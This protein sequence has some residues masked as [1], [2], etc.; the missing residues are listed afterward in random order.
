MHISRD[1]WCSISPPLGLDGL[2]VRVKLTDTGRFKI[3]DLYMHGAE[4]S[5]EALRAVSVS[6]LEAAINAP[7]SQEKG[8]LDA[9]AQGGKGHQAD[10]DLTLPALRERAV[11]VAERQQRRAR[12]LGRPTG[13][14][15][16]QFYREV[17]F[18]Y[19]ELARTTRA[20]AKT[21]A[22]ESEVPTTTVHRWVR[23]A[24]QRGF[25][26]PGEKGRAG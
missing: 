24:R 17:A 9:W 12:K 14:N 5:A 22:E 13:E 26:P 15:P 16:D 6:R 7:T 10:D 8:A 11:K 4:V 3:T 20:P 25:L 18:A 19:S 23:E 2:H 1:G 21:L